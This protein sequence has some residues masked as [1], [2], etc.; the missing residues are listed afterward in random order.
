MNYFKNKELGFAK[1]AIIIIDLPNNKSIKTLRDEI[2]RIPGVEMASLSNTPPSSGSV[3]G[4]GFKTEDGKEYGTQVKAVDDKYIPLYQLTMLA[5]KNVIDLDSVQGCIVNEKL[6]KMIGYNNPSDL[7]GK[8]LDFWGK[9]TEVIGVIK[10]FHTVSLHQSID[11]TI[12]F[13]SLSAYGN[14]SVKVNQAKFQEAIKE[15]QQKWDAA[16]PDFLFSYQ[17]MDEQIK[18]FYEREEK[19]STLLTVFTSVA[20]FIGCLG[21]FGL[22][23]FMAN[24]KTKEIGVRKVLGASVESIVFSFSKEY[25][26]LIVIGFLLAAPAA[27]YIMN[28]WLNGF[29]YKITLGPAIFIKAL[30]ITFIIAVITVGYRSYQAAM[31]NPA[32]SLRSE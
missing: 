24:Q 15:I 18:N 14:L 10:D 22:A 5:G 4:T 3:S 31:L 7:V 32:K 20:I 6:A 1:D 26:K 16:Y 25:V 11:A 17:F 9:K 23:T 21:L 2:S 30:A 19:M 28:Q 8:R 13:N 27:W 12:M 29:A